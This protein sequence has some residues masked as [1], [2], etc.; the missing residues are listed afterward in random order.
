MVLAAI[1]GASYAQSLIA[2]WPLDASQT[3]GSTSSDPSVATVTEEG[4]VRAVADG[5]A[6]V[7]AS[8]NGLSAT[9]TVRV[10]PEPSQ[11]IQIVAAMLC[12]VLLGRRRSGVR[13]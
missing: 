5:E 13:R 9:T 3:L 7:P 8:S 6:I 12:V 11:T 1:S 4:V 10:A 2:H